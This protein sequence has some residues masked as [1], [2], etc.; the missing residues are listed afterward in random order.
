MQKHPPTSSRFLPL[1]L[2]IRRCVQGGPSGE[3]SKSK[4][5]WERQLPGVHQILQPH[6]CGERRGQI[7][8]S[9]R[10]SHFFQKSVKDLFCWANRPCVGTG[11]QV[12]ANPV[13]QDFHSFSPRLC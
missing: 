6:S 9:V 1:L 5:F 13:Y 10:C 4:A 8:A 3:E 11:T 7:R 12:T 2:A